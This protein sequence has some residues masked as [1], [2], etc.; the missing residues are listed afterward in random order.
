MVWPRKPWL[1][2]RSDH[3]NRD[4]DHRL[5]M[6]NRDC[7]D[8]AL[9]KKSSECDHGLTMI[10]PWKNRDRDHYLTMK[11]CD[12]NHD[13]TIENRDYND[14]DLTMKNRDYDN[15]LTMENSDYDHDLSMRNRDYGNG[16]TRKVVFVTT[17]WPWNTVIMTIIW[18]WKTVIMTMV[19]PRKAVIGHL[20]DDVILLLRPESFRGLLSCAN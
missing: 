2:S 3:K 19:W 10:R 20:H 6:K 9:N 18:P 14:H 16:L 7:I 4:Y 15:G 8:N 12:S 11:N 17:I 5:T 1:W 13:L